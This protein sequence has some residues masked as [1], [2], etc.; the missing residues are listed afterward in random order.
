LVV[1]R[2]CKRVI[3]ILIDDNRICISVWILLLIVYALSARTGPY[4]TI[5]I[6]VHTNSLAVR[7][8]PYE[9]PG[10]LTDPYE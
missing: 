3:H 10:I 2:E 9:K 8:D 4:V 5:T 6:R 7:T 1:L